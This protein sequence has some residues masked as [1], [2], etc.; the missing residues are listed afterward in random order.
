VLEAAPLKLQKHHYFLCRNDRFPSVSSHILS[1]SEKE[2]TLPCPILKAV[3]VID[4]KK[5]GL[6]S[7][8]ATDT[9]ISW[10]DFYQPHV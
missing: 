7:S 4:G 3:V 10:S 8:F 2:Q 5:N 1:Y 6:L 9:T